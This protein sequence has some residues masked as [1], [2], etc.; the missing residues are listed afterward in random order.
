MDRLTRIMD[1]QAT[2]QEQLGYDVETMT[3]EERSIYIQKQAQHMAHEMHEMLQE[4]PYFKEWKKY[5]E[6]TF[7]LW[8]MFDSAR[9][10]W[11]D[12]LHFFVNITLGLGFT[13]ES[14]LSGYMGKNAVNHARQLDTENYKP[15]VV[16]E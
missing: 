4:L 13:A 7:D 15:C 5:P 3:L 14:L 16:P 2:L 10:E 9:A 6:D 11:I 1:K 12:V 8:N